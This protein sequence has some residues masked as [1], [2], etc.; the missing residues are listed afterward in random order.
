MK[1]PVL[2]S[3]SSVA[4]LRHPG[5][6]HASNSA[7]RVT[8]PRRHRQCN[9]ALRSARPNCDSRQ[10]QPEGPFDFMV[11]TGSQVTVVD[12]SLA[13]ELGLKAQGTVGLITVASYMH[14]SLTVPD[15][16]E[17]DSHVVEK[18]PVVVQDLGPIQ[19]AD[20]RIRG[21]LGENFLAHF[22]LL[23]DY[24]YKLLCLDET[25]AMRESVRGERILLHDAAT[26]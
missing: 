19:A 11:D 4:G 16:L 10:N 14:A 6:G 1:Q 22:D 21:V 9:P 18:P 12:P 23:I 2:P 15:T 24:A 8:L 25:S 5:D 20:P 13:Q 7:G 17:A 3:Q 26:S